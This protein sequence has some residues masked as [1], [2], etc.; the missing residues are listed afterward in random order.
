MIDSALTL[1]CRSPPLPDNL[2]LTLKTLDSTVRKLKEEKFYDFN[3]MLEEWAR[4]EII[5][6]VPKHE[7]QLSYCYLPRIHVVEGHSTN[8]I[9]PPSDASAKL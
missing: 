8:T 9:R 5:E 6:E 7:I 2:N 1:A 3:Q 4:K